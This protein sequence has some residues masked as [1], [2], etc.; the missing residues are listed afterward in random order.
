MHGAVTD[1]DGLGSVP[2]HFGSEV[3][4]L[5]SSIRFG[6][7]YFRTSGLLV[8]KRFKLTLL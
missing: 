3:L 5:F 7:M 6:F 1:G 2:V 4:C 8:L